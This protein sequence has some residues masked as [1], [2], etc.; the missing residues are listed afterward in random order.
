MMTT[1]EYNNLAGIIVKDVV[2][3]QRDLDNYLFILSNN[4]VDDAV[5]F[6]D[7]F[8]NIRM[9]ISEFKRFTELR[10]DASVIQQNDSPLMESAYR[11][12]FSG[13]Y[14]EKMLQCYDSMKPNRIDETGT[15]E[16]SY[17]EGYDQRA[18]YKHCRECGKAIHKEAQFCQYC[19]KS[20]N[21]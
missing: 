11:C 14:V 6:D 17:M 10:D 2:L 18:S 21:H 16:L 5:S 8:D 20:T 1:S 19:G 15:G 4:Y 3:K 7:Y 9:F 13:H 12:N